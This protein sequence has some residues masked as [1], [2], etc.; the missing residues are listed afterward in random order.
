MSSPEPLRLTVIGCGYL[1]TT[2]AASFASLGFEVLG[3]DIDHSRLAQLESG[4]SPV[5]EPGLSDL[6]A[7]QVASGRLRFTS[8]YE[9]AAEHGDVH[10]VCVATPTEP[11]AG[12]VE[13]GQVN[14]VAEDLFPLLT[15]PCTVVG[16]STVPVGTAAALAERLRSS[17]PAGPQA[18]LAWSPEFLR[19]G[20]AIHDTLSPDRIVIGVGEDCDQP[21]KMLREVY[22]HHADRGVPVVV[23]D[24]ATAELAKLAA[25]AFLATKIS[26]INAMAEICE[27]TGADIDSLSRVLGMDARIGAHGLRA[28]VGFGGGCLPKDVRGFIAAADGLGTPE[29]LRFLGEVEAINQR[30]RERLVQRASSLLQDSWSR[31]RVAVLGAAFK[32]GSDD[33][34]DSPALDI[35]A[36]MHLRGAR[37]VIHDPRAMGNASE[38][39]PSLEYA[40]TAELACAGADLV[41]LLTEWPEYV[42]LDPVSLATVVRHAR[43]VDGRNCLDAESWTSAGWTY[44]GVGRGTS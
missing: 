36:R 23:V 34:R 21:V 42:A 2:T 43:V 35:A 40:P 44:R 29:A 37:V 32:P 18:H 3:V 15:R 41:L 12:G 25:N 10:L 39:W 6:L 31:S 27:A 24:L 11:A 28:G 4:V 26:F 19:E 38:L 30:Q 14:N 33:V 13:L 20:Y 17:A 5:Y 22:A 8:S 9:H 1:G 7:T 16:K